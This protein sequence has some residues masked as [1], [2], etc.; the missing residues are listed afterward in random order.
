MS[1]DD[2]RRPTRRR[3]DDDYD[4]RPRRRRD[5]AGHGS[6]A[7]LT[8]FGGSMGCLFAVLVAVGGIVT[9][10]VVLFSGSS[11]RT[12]TPPAPP[13]PKQRSAEVRTM[14]EADKKKAGATVGKALAGVLA[15]GGRMWETVLHSIKGNDW[16]SVAAVT[17]SGVR[18]IRAEL[19]VMAVTLRNQFADM[20]E[21]D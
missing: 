9:L 1:R 4:D 14:T 11:R 10:L 7:F 8:M 12:E 19:K 5:D 15:T 21:R 17:S 6:S 3:R 20:A 18:A 2:D 13:P 16:K